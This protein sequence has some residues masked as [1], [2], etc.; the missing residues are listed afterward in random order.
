LNTFVLTIGHVATL[1][2]GP[3]GYDVVESLP[4]SGTL[5]ANPF[6]CGLEAPLLDKLET[7]GHYLFEILSSRMIGD[8][9]QEPS[10][11]TLIEAGENRQ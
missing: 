9:I 2:V 3:R 1:D 5:L 10:T 4:Y 6:F 7:H 8:Q 11:W